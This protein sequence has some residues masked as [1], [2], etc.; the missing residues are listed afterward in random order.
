VLKE[1]L[2]IINNERRSITRQSVNEIT[3]DLDQTKSRGRLSKVVI[4]R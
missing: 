2:N 4:E 3:K 1:Q